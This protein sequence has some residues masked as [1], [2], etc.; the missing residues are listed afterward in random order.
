MSLNSRGTFNVGVPRILYFSNGLA[1]Y[2]KKELNTDN[3][4]G[5]GG[6]V[7]RAFATL[8]ENLFGASRSGSAY[9]PRTFKQIIGRSHSAF[10][11]YQQQDSQEFLAFLLDGLH[12]DLNRIINKPATE[13]PELKDDSA[14]DINA[15]A[16]LAE[17]SWKS[18]KLRNESVILDLFGGLYKSTLVCPECSLTSV[19]FD[20]FMDLT[21]P[22]PSSQIWTKEIFVFPKTGAPTLL[23][24]ELHANSSGDNL[25][26]HISNKLKVEPDFL[27]LVEIYQTSFFRN[28][29]QLGSVNEI[30]SGDDSND[31]LAV[32]EADFKLAELEPEQFL[33]PVYFQ[34]GPS[35]TVVKPMGIPFYISLSEAEAA[36]PAVIARKV[37]GKCAQINE[38]AAKAEIDYDNLPFTLAVYNGNGDAPACDWRIYS[39][40]LKPLITPTPEPD[41]ESLKVSESSSQIS[42]VELETPNSD[43]LDLDQQTP[44][45]DLP[46]ADETNVPYE[47]PVALPVTPV[48]PSPI[49]SEMSDNNEYANFAAMLDESAI[50]PMSLLGQPRPQEA[51]PSL[52]KYDTL[53]CGWD[54]AMFEQV[55]G[56]DDISSTIAHHPDPEL[57]EVRAKRAEKEAQ[58]ITLDD[59]LDQ[60]SR[61]EVLGEDDLWHCSRCRDFRRAS[62][63]IELWKTPDIFT[64]HLKRFSSYHG[65]RDKLADVVKFPIKGLDMTQRIQAT[66]A[67]GV[68]GEDALEKDGHIYDLFAVDNHYGG[69][70][71]G[72][73]TAFAKNFV[74]DKWYYYDDSRV[75]EADPEDAITGAAYL[76]FYRRRSSEPLGGK[77]LQE[78][79]A[80]A[81]TEP[82]PEM[83]QEAETPFQGQGQT[84]GSGS[85]SSGGLPWDRPRLKLSDTE[86]EADD[87]DEEDDDDDRKED[88]DDVD[89]EPENEVGFRVS[90]VSS[91]FSI[92]S[93]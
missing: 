43:A 49:A 91:E 51:P 17:D 5:H 76:L 25:K 80:K 84:L 48:V 58:G 34:I 75:R 74:D 85:T 35:G 9:S 59:C 89:Y 31:I 69:L 27:H 93:I 57:A 65:F 29:S 79:L 13:K 86:S 41:V 36:D 37:L 83:A 67:N 21:L 62:K 7:A 61:T 44:D 71:G 28:I 8:L 1:G 53:V 66:K 12:E 30:S 64:I 6:Q 56:T 2:F 14:T 72:H 20:P 38:Q 42:A 60:F 4:I 47:E 50:A 33:V 16:Q 78:I 70:G 45:S 63:T 3:P 82:E 55:F 11:G 40:R 52:G 26:E 39:S 24:V 77:G 92:S 90:P 10:A 81:E 88:D 68:V 15:I 23:S 73:Y 32:Y 46:D 22:L 18:H 19:T 87:A 54:A